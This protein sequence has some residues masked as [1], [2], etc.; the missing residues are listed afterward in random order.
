MQR[1]LVQCAAMCALVSASTAARA[2]DFWKYW[3]DGKAELDGYTL[4]EPRYGQLRQGTAVAIFVTED[5]SDALRVKADPGK[6]PKS[7]IVPVMKVNLVRDFQTGIY[8]YNTMTSTFLRTEA[9]REGYWG[10][11]KTSFSSQ[12][13]C[14]QVY[15]QWLPRGTHLVGTSHSYF[16]GEADAAPELELPAGAVLED[17]LPILVRGLRGE[18]LAAGATKKVAFLRS[19]LRTRLLHVPAKW[20]EAT[21][22]RAAASADVKT[23]LGRMR[24]F[25][26]TVAEKDGDT[27]TFTVEEAA[28]HRL[29]AWESS[30]GESARIVGSARLEYWKMHDNGDEKALGQLGLVPQ[31]VPPKRQT[32]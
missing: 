3:G 14:G 19:Q 7:D 18:W 30:S 32:R 5:F 8:D 24:S 9:D 28:P 31:T 6:H 10:L 13:W 11:M 4:V 26:Y 23:A 16:D 21:V 1:I 12:E 17:A 15:M 20:G 22:S 27:I 29:L 2:D 25:V